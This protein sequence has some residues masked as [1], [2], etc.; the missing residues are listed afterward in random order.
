MDEI[1][2]C[3]CPRPGSRVICNTCGGYRLQ[4]PF[5]G[6]QGHDAIETPTIWPEPVRRVIRLVL[7]A[8][9]AV[10]VILAIELPLGWWPL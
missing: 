4:P 3:C 8:L 5:L 10:L 9:V 6:G 2:P 1:H 7:V